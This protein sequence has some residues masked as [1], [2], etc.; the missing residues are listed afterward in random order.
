MNDPGTS[1]VEVPTTAVEGTEGWLDFKFASLPPL[2][3][4][5]MLTIA[6]FDA[7]GGVLSSGTA[8]G[9]VGG[10]LGL[11]SELVLL[12]TPESPSS[13]YSIGITFGR[14]IT[15]LFRF[16]AT[17]EAD[18]Q[19]SAFGFSILDAS[20]MMPLLLVDDWPRLDPSGFAFLA[21]LD[22]EGRASISSYVADASY[23]G[24]TRP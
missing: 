21:D 1:R 14:R 3:V 6:G 7:H 15:F 17:T 16:K 10:V 8:T 9:N 5:A 22:G 19:G 24:S 18:G 2:P 23:S 13:E 4:R 12:N 20:S 11:E